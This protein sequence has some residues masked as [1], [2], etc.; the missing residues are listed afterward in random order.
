VLAAL[1]DPG[2]CRVVVV[3]NGSTDGTA[4]VARAAGATVV[5]EPRRGYGA[6]CLAGLAYLRADPPAI[7]AFLD[8]DASDDPAQLPEVLAPILAGTADLVIGSR[9]LGEREP[10]ALTVVQLLG[11]RLAVALLRVLFG[12]PYTDLGPFRAIRWPA[13]ERLGMRDRDYGWTVE[14]QAR[15][16]RHRLRGVE[17]PVRYRRR[18]GRSKI[19]GTLRGSLSA[20]WKILF[21]IA[22]VRL[23]G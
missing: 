1:G 2:A 15:A 23:G 5:H 22:R 9:V 12:A 4:A 8:A 14:M 10:G 11:N 6:A 20:G 16:A 18:V 21:T 13:L 7:V 3:D 17:V 19:S